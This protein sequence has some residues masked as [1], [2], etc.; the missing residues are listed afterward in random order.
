MTLVVVLRQEIRPVRRFYP[1]SITTVVRGLA[2]FYACPWSPKS[3]AERGVY[4]VASAECMCTSWLAGMFT[5][6]DPGQICL[7]YDVAPHG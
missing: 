3:L 6:V 7:V 1:K 5:V 4:I 2:F